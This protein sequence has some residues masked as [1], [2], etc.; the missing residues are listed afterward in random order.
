M[1]GGAERER[2]H[3]L[4]GLACG[5]SRCEHFSAC[6][7]RVVTFGGGT[8]ASVS[9]DKSAGI[10][11]ARYAFHMQ[12]SCAGGKCHHKQ[13]SW[14]GAVGHIKWS[15]SHY[16]HPLL[17]LSGGRGLSSVCAFGISSQRQLPLSPAVPPRI[18]RELIVSGDANWALLKAAALF[19]RETIPVSMNPSLTFLQVTT[20]SSVPFCKDWEPFSSL[21]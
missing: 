6:F 9:S 2:E 12:L 10:F 21:F 20:A 1:V 15:G 4:L 19:C 7:G 13:G 5:E 11:S 18:V 8:S 16:F 3:Y 14:D 17:T